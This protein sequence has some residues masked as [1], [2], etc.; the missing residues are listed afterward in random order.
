MMCLAAAGFKETHYRAQ[1]T[2]AQ[3]RISFSR[4]PYEPACDSTLNASGRKDLS[5]QRQ[6][7]LAVDHVSGRLRIHALDLLVPF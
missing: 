4:R 1:R 5:K 2:M 6:E 3:E 7:V